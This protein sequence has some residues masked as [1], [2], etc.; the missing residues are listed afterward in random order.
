VPAPPSAEDFQLP[1]ES[2]KRSI[3]VVDDNVDAATSLATL[4][5]MVGHDVEIEHDGRA[6][7]ERISRAVPD[8][9][10]LDI[11]LPGMSGY[12]VAKQL[13]SRPEGQGLRIYAMTGYG[14]EDDRKR[15]MESGF[16][17]HLVKPVM[18]A[19]LFR[20]IDDAQPA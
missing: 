3:L 19:E 8:L 14:Q 13:R 7:L 9:V 16:N 4:L 6:A 5:R 18:P 12:E 1:R 17:G 2:P 11:G 20:L 15:S 10:L